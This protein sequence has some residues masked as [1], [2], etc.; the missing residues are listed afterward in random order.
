MNLAGIAISLPLSLLSKSEPRRPLAF[1]LRNTQ[2]LCVSVILV[3][4][5]LTTLNG[6]GVTGAAPSAQA[7]FASILIASAMLSIKNMR[8]AFRR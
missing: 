4:L 6:A 3:K 5:R 7:G 2:M 8:S 1:D